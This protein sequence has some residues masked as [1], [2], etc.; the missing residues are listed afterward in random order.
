MD[1]EEV[2]ERSPERFFGFYIE[3]ALGGHGYQTTYLA[4]GSYG[5]A[6]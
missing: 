4:A 2:N 6:T 5:F 3:P 1:I